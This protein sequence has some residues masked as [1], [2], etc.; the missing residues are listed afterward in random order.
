MEVWDLYD[1]YKNVTGKKCVRG[2]IIPDN[3]Y[4]LVVHVWIK[5]KKG[6]YLISQRSENKHSFPLM[7]ECVGGAVLQGENSI[8]GAIRETKEEVGINLSKEKGNLIF[9]KVRDTING[10]RFNDIMDVWL[11]EY[12]GEID[13]NNATTDEVKDSRWMN[14]NEIKS[15]FDNKQLVPTL[16]Y[17]FDEFNILGLKTGTVKLEEHREEWAEMFNS[18]R[19]ELEKIFGNLA[20]DIQHIGSTSIS[21]ISAKPI[22]DIAIGVKKLQDFNKVSKYFINYPYSIKE[23][24]VADERLVRKGYPQTSYLIHIM[25]IDSSRYKDTIAFR[26]YLNKNHKKAK[27]YESLKKTLAIKYKNDRKKYTESKNE[28]IKSIIEEANSLN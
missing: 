15:L 20:I 8:D 5:N 9:S 28:F 10:K 13:L 4:H 22:I 3:Y 1:K 26:D 14:K 2:D 17:F 12:N 23:D 19:K 25:E 21:N 7:W 24:S 27:E 18:E 11:F 6:E 16:S